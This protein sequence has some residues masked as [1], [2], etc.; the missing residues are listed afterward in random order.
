M[1]VKRGSKWGVRI[2]DKTTQKM[3]WRGT[4][5]TK[6]EAK[7]AEARATLKPR[8]SKPVTVADW[9]A[10]WLSDYARPAAASRN[11]YRY[12]AKPVVEALGTTLLADVNRPLARKHAAIWSHSVTK[13]ARAMF[14][15]AM[16]DGLIEF[17]PFTGLRIE[18]PRGRKD[19]DAL[20]EAEIHELAGIAGQH[21][22]PDYGP[23]CA[24]IILT[25][26]FVGLRPG[27]LC[28]LRRADLNLE[29]QEV[30][31]RMNTGADGVEKLPKNGKPRI[32]T[33]AVEVLD[34]LA[35][36]PARIDPD[37]RLFYTLRGQPFN[38][39]NLNYWWRPIGVAWAAKGNK[40]I[41]LYALRHACATLMLE[42]GL[43]VWDVAQQLGH[44]DGG[45]LVQTLYGHPSE[46]ASR[47]RRRLAMSQRP[48]Q[49]IEVY[50]RNT[51][52]GSAA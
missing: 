4:F 2:W 24:A 33:L 14:G 29:H 46:Q 48:A 25:L 5:D 45:R 38:K 44:S 10:I 51:D 22:G 13:V 35:R 27:E 6:A 3:V 8:R 9:A 34:A 52:T 32:I 50:R 15:D 12:G 42:R 41:S 7:S 20:T 47:E 43:S 40:P 17:N 39:G 1:I 36:V 11:N 28:S 30:T 23:E 19:I 21:Y 31:V 26:G 37:A 16:R 18:T 49:P